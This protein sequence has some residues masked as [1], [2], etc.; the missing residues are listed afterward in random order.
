MMPT[1][2][3]VV[4]TASYLADAKKLMTDQERAEIVTRIAEDPTCGDL[5]V[6]GGGVRKVRHAIGNKG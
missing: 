1:L 6:G 5:I 2:L 4:E 3:T